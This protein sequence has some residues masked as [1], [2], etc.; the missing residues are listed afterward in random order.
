MNE[1]QANTLVVTLVTIINLLLAFL[2]SG[3]V[4]W[5]L[6][7]DPWFALKTMLYGAFGY[8]EGLG[9]H[10]ITPPILFSL[11][12]PLQ[13][14]SIADCLILVQKDKHTLADWVLVWFVCGWKAGRFGWF[15][16]WLFWHPLF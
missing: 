6:G 7:E 11:D 13:S 1:T 4:I 10:C 5:V 15:F 3:I 14:D 9:T 12:W 16:H 2:V 8:D